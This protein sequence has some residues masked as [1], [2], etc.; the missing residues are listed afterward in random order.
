MEPVAGGTPRPSRP[1]PNLAA[2]ASARDPEMEETARREMVTTPL[3]PPEEGQVEY[4]LFN[5]VFVQLLVQKPVVH[6][7]YIE[8]QF[9]QS[10]GLKGR[11][12]VSCAS[13]VRFPPASLTSRQQ[14]VAQEHPSCPFV[15]PGKG[16]N[17]SCHHMPGCHKPQAGFLHF[18]P[19]EEESGECCNSHPRLCPLPVQAR[20]G[21]YV[22]P[23]C[24]TVG[25][26]VA[27]LVP[28]ARSLGAWLA[29][30]SP[31][32]WLLRTIRLGYAI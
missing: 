8:E 17:T 27:P 26:L 14:W 31:S 15:K 9:P 18:L 3:P 6:T 4:L 19:H 12:V 13:W 23:S 29:I 5:F 20:P 22:P 24:P 11:R 32:R 28:L 2:S 21:P 1:P 30:P 25:T 16:C 10:L 7:I